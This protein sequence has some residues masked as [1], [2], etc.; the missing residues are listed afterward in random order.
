MPIG[1]IVIRMI[2][3]G[4]MP[5]APAVIIRVTPIVV[6]VPIGSVVVP[7]MV[8]IMPVP[9]VVAP[10][11]MMMPIM[12]VVPVIVG[13]DEV[14]GPRDGRQGVQGGSRSTARR[15]G[16]GARTGWRCHSHSKPEH[17]DGWNVEEGFRRHCSVLWFLLPDP[18]SLARQKLQILAPAE[19]KES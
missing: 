13:L 9:I 6:P 17:E 1:V 16:L 18:N 2:I 12:M 8:I 19:L 3:V 11:I 4:A 5:V 14:R 10:I 15:H 7:V